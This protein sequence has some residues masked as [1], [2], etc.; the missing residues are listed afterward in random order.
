MDAETSARSS[1]EIHQDISNGE[2]SWNWVQ[3]VKVLWQQTLIK[4]TNKKVA[5]AHENQVADRLGES[6]NIKIQR[7]EE[8][9]RN[10]NI[11]QSTKNNWLKVW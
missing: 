6:N 8:N 9:S 1:A 2:E 7:S 11:S 4:L 5:I 3:K 10:K